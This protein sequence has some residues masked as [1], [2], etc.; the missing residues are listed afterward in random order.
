MVVGG[1]L[2]YMVNEHFGLVPAS[3]TIHRFVYDKDKIL[4]TSEVAKQL[5]GNPSTF[6]VSASGWGFAFTPGLLLSTSS[7]SVRGFAQLGLG[8]YHHSESVEILKQPDDK[9]FNKFA[10]LLGGGAEVP[11]TDKASFVGQARYQL[12]ATDDESTSLLGV[13]GSVKYY[14]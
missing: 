6:S 12:I 8:L 11:L 14:F 5:P 3:F 4:E 13:L 9:N 1:D 10:A 2:A 7:E